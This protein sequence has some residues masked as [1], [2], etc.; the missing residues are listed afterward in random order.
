MEAIL[1]CCG[2]LFRRLYFHKQDIIP[3]VLS[4]HHNSS[5]RSACQCMER[6]TIHVVPPSKDSAFRSC[7]LSHEMMWK[8]HSSLLAEEESLVL[9]RFMSH[10]LT[11]E[12]IPYPHS[13]TDSWFV[14]IITHLVRS[15]NYHPS[16][17]QPQP[18][19]VYLSVNQRWV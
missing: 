18:S 8:I 1:T 7:T 11:F 2:Q 10:I 3:Y 5:T 19:M 14:L 13:H 12:L 4:E 9:C 16:G 17:L 15:L 6:S